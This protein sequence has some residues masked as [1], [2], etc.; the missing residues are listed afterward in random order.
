[1]EMVLAIEISNNES[2]DVNL[3]TSLVIPIDKKNITE[4]TTNITNI[5]LIILE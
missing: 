3:A 1:M 4:P 5:N 2:K